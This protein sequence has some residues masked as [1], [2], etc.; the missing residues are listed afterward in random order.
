MVFTET[1]ILNIFD[2]VK[3]DD[4]SYKISLKGNKPRQ[5]GMKRQ[6]ESWYIEENDGKG[7]CMFEAMSQILNGGDLDPKDYNDVPEYKVNGKYTTHSIDEQ[8]IDYL[9]EQGRELFNF[10]RNNEAPQDLVELV[11]K[12]DELQELTTKQKQDIMQYKFMLNDDNSEFMDDE[13]IIDKFQN[14]LTQITL[15]R[16]NLQKRKHPSFLMI[17]IIGVTI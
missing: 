4:G 9:R 13:M 16:L 15:M 10:Y 6:L 12:Q 5:A 14:H 7:D 2:V 3:K 8:L 1:A 17:N 11:K